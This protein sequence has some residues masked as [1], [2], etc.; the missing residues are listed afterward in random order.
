M[1]KKTLLILLIIP[2]IISLLTFVSIQ[3]L[4]NS[5]ASDILGISWKYDEN[6]GFQIDPENGYLL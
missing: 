6:E 2:F 4:D 3:I 1:K 5:V